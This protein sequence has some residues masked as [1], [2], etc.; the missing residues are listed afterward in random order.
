MPRWK[1]LPWPSRE[2]RHACSSSCATTSINA[3]AFPAET[4]IRLNVRL[5]AGELPGPD[6]TERA[7]KA[8]EAKGFRFCVNN[9]IRD[10]AP[11]G[12]AVR[13]ALAMA[14]LRSLSDEE[15]LDILSARHEMT[16][17]QREL[18][19]TLMKGLRG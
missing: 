6:W 15:V 7:R 9:P 10:E 18:V 16:D 4:Y 1:L 5:G 2:G 12:R 14:E 13:K 8:C 17:R 11:A 19:G 3:A